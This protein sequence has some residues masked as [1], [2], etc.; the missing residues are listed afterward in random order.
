MADDT[1]KRL[2]AFGVNYEKADNSATTLGDRVTLLSPGALAGGCIDGILAHEALHSALG[3][4]KVDEVRR[5]IGEPTNITTPLLVD[6]VDGQSI[7]R[8][9]QSESEWTVQ[10]GARDCFECAP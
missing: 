10:T 1:W 6:E 2:T 3:T 8:L 5:P 7:S 9:T 4:M